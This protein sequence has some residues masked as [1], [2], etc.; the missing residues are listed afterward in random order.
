MKIRPILFSTPMVKALLS[1][2]K[3]MTRRVVKM[4]P[5]RFVTSNKPFMGESGREYKCP[6][7]EVGDILWVRE[8]FEVHD[9]F[10]TYNYKADSKSRISDKW[11][12]SLFMPKDACRIFLKITNVRVEKLNDISEEDSTKEGVIRMDWEFKNGE[13]PQT[14]KEAFQLLWESINGKGGWEENP[15]L[16]VIEFEKCKKPK[17]FK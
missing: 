7:G 9:S 1:G 15:W 17:N 12:P 2:V 13:C 6:Y 10:G 3:T 5:S 14:D 4:P 8:T 16:W 11:L